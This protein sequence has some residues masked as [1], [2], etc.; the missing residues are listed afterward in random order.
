MMA[1]AEVLIVCAQKGV[2]CGL[3]DNRIMMFC[4]LLILISSFITPIFLKFSYRK[5][6]AMESGEGNKAIEK[7]ANNVANAEVG[8]GEATGKEGK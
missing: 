2:D 8:S 4:L 6:M 3:V 5:E 1:R 7:M